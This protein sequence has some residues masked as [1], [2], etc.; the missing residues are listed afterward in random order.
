MC[1]FNCL[2]VCRQVTAADSLSDVVS[3]EKT[4]RGRW[5]FM[6]AVRQKDKHR[7]ASQ[8]HSNTQGLSSII[9]NLTTTATAVCSASS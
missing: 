7:E 3:K 4:G 6:R 2:C 8:Q 5:T 9:N 1:V